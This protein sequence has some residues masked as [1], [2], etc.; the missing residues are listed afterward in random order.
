MKKNILCLPVILGV[1]GLLFGC[2]E[3][4]KVVRI[5]R[6]L[7]QARE[8][9]LRLFQELDGFKLEK[10]LE[11]GLSG[12]SAVRMEGT[13]THAGQQRKGIIYVIEHPKLFNVI[14]YTAPVENGMFDAGYPGFL[15]M[16][17]SLKTLDFQG[18]LSVVELNDEKVMRSADLKLQ[19]HYP[20]SWVYSLDE[21][22]RA[23]V[24]SG[25]RSDPTWLTTVNFSVINK[26]DDLP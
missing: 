18:S 17:K 5:S 24:F 20:T 8:I 7:A 26:W 2:S 19:I 1:V 3:T 10:Q 4:K 6:T 13:W 14:H 25:P 16:I 22:N 12:H 9:A 23:I 11:V 15:K 21:V